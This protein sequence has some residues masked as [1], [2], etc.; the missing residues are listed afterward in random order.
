MHHSYRIEV[1]YNKVNGKLNKYKYM[2]KQYGY[3]NLGVWAT[4]SFTSVLLRTWKT[5]KRLLQLNKL[6][7]SIIK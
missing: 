5:I 1:H 7:E 6:Q 3:V 2:N 4:D